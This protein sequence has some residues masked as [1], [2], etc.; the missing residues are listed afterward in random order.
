MTRLV[1]RIIYDA[2]N[3]NKSVAHKQL[4]RKSRLEGRTHMHSKIQ[5]WRGG[6]NGDGVNDFK[7]KAPTRASTSGPSW[8]LAVVQRRLK[9]SCGCQGGVKKVECIPPSGETVADP[10]KR[11]IPLGTK[12]R[13]SSTRS[14]K[15]S[16]GHAVSFR[17][18]EEEE[19][20]EEGRL[21]NVATTRKTEWERW[22]SRP[23]DHM[24]H[25]LCPISGHGHYNSVLLDPLT[26]TY[27][28]HGF[29]TILIPFQSECCSRPTR[30]IRSF[31]RNRNL[32]FWID[33]FRFCFL[34]ASSSRRCQSFCVCVC[35]CLV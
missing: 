28:I 32:M 9:V 34:P 22:V 33:T 27:S 11:L 1:R 29:I 4:S 3:I 18:E 10:G 19:E 5:H 26:K 35:V 31:Q 23:L 30:P 7:G 12:S 16:T 21:S 14:L 24:C 8:S 20:E 6:V 17:E 25:E 2:G 13:E 15:A